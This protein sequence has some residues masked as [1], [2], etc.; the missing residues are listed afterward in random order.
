MAVAGKLKTYSAAK[1]ELYTEMWESEIAA[2][3]PSTGVGIKA[4]NIWEQRWE[5]RGL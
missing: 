3:G 2:Q 5:P 1:G 4:W